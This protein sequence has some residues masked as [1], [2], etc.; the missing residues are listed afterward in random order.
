M[1]GKQQIIIG[2]DKFATGMAATDYAS[3]GALGNSSRNMNPF[4]TPGVVRPIG[5]VADKST[6]VTGGFIAS[7]EDSQT[8][9]AFNRVF[10]DDEGGY[11]T[12]NG[13]TITK[14][15]TG[16]A[17]TKYTSGF[18]DQVGFVGNT[19]TTLLG[20]I[21]QLNTSGSITLDETWWT[22]T[23]SQ[24]FHFTLS[25]PHPLL[26]FEGQ[27]W[28]GDGNYMHTIDSGLTVVKDVLVLNANERIQALGIDPGSGLMLVSI[29]TTQNYSDTLSTRNYVYLYDGYST[30]PRRKMAVDDLV[31]AFYNVGGDVFVGYGNKIGVF[32]GSGI[33]Y[34]RTLKN[35]VLGTALGSDL[36]Y[37]HKF[38]N[39]GNILLVA[40]GKDLLAYGEVIMGQ[41]F[42]FNVFQ[43]SVNS[44]SISC[45][46]PL[47]GASI[48]IAFATD[49][50][51]IADL[52]NTTSLPGDFSMYT[53]WI[54][55]PRP[56]HIRSVR[57]VTTGVTTTLGTGGVAITTDREFRQPP[58]TTGQFVVTAGESPRQTFD[59]QFTGMKPC[60]MLQPRISSSEQNFGIAQVI[61]YYDVAE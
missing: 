43:N 10:V 33:T 56:I 13:T 3:D 51:Y 53:S 60:S 48:G 31:T 19:Y 46:S 52:A 16:T 36:L 40:D 11:Y 61:I 23:K 49:K 47:G 21:S 27:L 22:V 59:F 57:I 54:Q 14:Q 41:K 32:N 9:S 15:E 4:V 34:L 58:T 2:A 29:Q 17:T 6:N 25:T 5:G 28:V 50:F 12:Y 35:I 38:S 1:I 55:L 39:V 24:T 44:N 30:K 26:V 45:V 18:T 42:W 20:D 7:S 37:R 8:V